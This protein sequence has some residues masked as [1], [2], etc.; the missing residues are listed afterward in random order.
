MLAVKNAILVMRDH[1]VPD[2][3]ILCDGDK[4]IDLGVGIDIPDGCETIDA[5]GFFAGPGLIDIHTHA[6]GRYWFYEEPEKA[7]KIVLSHGVTTVLPVVYFSM[8]KTDFLNAA[9]KIKSSADSGVFPNFGGFYME[10]P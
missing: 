10:G 7:G 5:E 3:S 2:A 1:L 4:I 8:N 6:A 9:L